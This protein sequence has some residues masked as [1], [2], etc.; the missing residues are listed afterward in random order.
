MPK[1]LFKVVWSDW[2]FY[3]SI[4][5]KTLLAFLVI[6]AVLAGG[7]Y[8]YTT[9]TF[10][11]HVEEEAL[12]ELKSK[13]QGAWRLF[14]SRLDQM[15]FGMLQASTDEAN[16][17][18]I[19]NRDRAFIR[20]T[21]DRYAAVRSY[22]DYW[23][24][25]DS[26]GRV[27]ARRN[28]LSGDIVDI[29][30]VVGKALSTGEPVLS[31]ESVSREFLSRESMELASRVE[32][33]GLM[34]FAVVP[35]VHRGEV[36]GAFVS[37]TLLNGNSWLS[38]SVYEY[39]SAKSA[40]FMI[41]PQGKAAVIASTGLPKGIFNPLTVLPKSSV[42]LLS[43]GSGYIG[44]TELDSDKVFLAVDPV[45]N[46]NGE[47]IG[48]LGLAEYASVAGEHVSEISSK[49]LIVAG[50][51][52][53]FSL[54][55]AGL[56]YKD[57]SRPVKA[58]RAAMDETAAGN[59]EIEVDIRTKD[60]FESIG[61]GF[62]Q[63]VESIRVREA[64]LDRFNQLS[65]IL[66]QYNDPDVLV[67]RA[68]SKIIELTDS[69]LGVVYTYDEASGTL[70]PAAFSGTGE[71]EVRKLSKGEGMAGRCIADQKT[72]LLQD[73]ASTEMNLEAGLLKVRPAGMVWFPMCYKNK[74]RGV[75][76][77]GSIKHYDHDEISHIE[78]LVAQL[79]IALD[80]ALI[81]REV[82]K[83]SVTDPLT[84][85]FNRRRFVEVVEDEFRSAMRYRYNL[86]IIMLDV[87][88]FKSINDTYGHQQ[89]DIVLT[90]LSRL[91]K[92]KTRTTDV[93][94]RY[95]GEE[96]VGLVTHSSAEGMFILAE[97]L[98]KSVEEHEFPGLKGRKVTISL[99][100][101]CFPS[102]GIKDIEDL[103]KVADDNLYKAKRSGKNMVVMMNLEK[104]RLVAE[105]A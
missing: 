75:L 59:L 4:G 90:E 91:I 31:T 10:S 33:R 12:T 79:S 23:A 14:Y 97:K 102:E 18:S 29:N 65:E 44:E 78:H 63:M 88:D 86:G 22:V 20:K 58:I 45:L 95:G 80:N 47:V 98:R 3:L 66:I 73:L 43:K 1:K 56:I 67:E 15:K 94:A 34:Q 53:L 39:F 25:V 27:I 99:G 60:E 48:A 7:F 9:V 100:V 77:L 50:V 81:H 101:S 37:G 71:G 55:L 5:A 42:G 85:V 69:Q 2:R 76:L 96:F 16:K 30:G 51:G 49:I 40:I 87:D 61:R 104:L 83:L 8:Y 54:L 19:I 6:I 46:I 52:I 41:E 72:M 32:A 92:E 38:R 64:R 62:N 82:E 89:G 84:G 68:L 11:S 57:T 28:A 21:L 36:I 35:A 70:K 26:E 13:S 103:M 105:G 24:V 17:S 74:P 93:W